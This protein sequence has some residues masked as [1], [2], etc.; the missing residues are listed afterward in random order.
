MR[1][2]NLKNELQDV[3]TVGIYCRS[4]TVDNIAINE[5]KRVLTQYA[6]D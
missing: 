5:Q 3:T 2:N 6:T 4:A 1:K